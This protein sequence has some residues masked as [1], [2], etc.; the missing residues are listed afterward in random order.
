[1][2]PS[3]HIEK[4]TPM[5]LRI[6]ADAMGQD[7]K[8]MA[9][10]FGIS[11]LKGLWFNYRNSLI[12][13]SVFIDNK[14][15]AIFGIGGMVFYDTGVPWIVL[16]PETKEYP[17]RIAF[18]F[19]R[20]LDKMAAM[21]PV[22]EDYIEETREREIKFMELMNFKVSKNVIKVDGVNFRRLERRACNI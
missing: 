15:C 13:K 11:P 18:A 17:M 6:M 3:I 14:I 1:M 22:L 20:E 12:C 2:T 16:T 5:H 7:S 8:E 21:F 9:E 4:T 19:R 10:R